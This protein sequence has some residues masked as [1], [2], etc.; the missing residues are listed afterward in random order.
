MIKK[1]FWAAAWLLCVNCG[2]LPPPVMPDTN[3]LLTPLMQPDSMCGFKGFG[4]VYFTVNGQRAKAK[5][6]VQWHGDSDCV[7]DVYSPLGGTL[8]SVRA[9]P[10]GAWTITQ[11]GSSLKKLP[12]DRVALIEG[13]EAYPFSYVQ[14][15][16]IIIGK[17]PN[18]SFCTQKPDSMIIEEKK[19]ALLWRADSAQGRPYAITALIHRKHSTI[20]DVLY[21][22]KGSTPW[23][24]TFSS[25]T[26]GNAKEIRFKD[27]HNNYFYVRYD[28]VVSQKKATGCRKGN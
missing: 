13:A 15:A 24:L 8:A 12:S 14:F 4:D 25:F 20:T 23:S 18:R 6:D 9:D 21:D 1:M 26:G 3:T 19:T 11:A 7:I 17:L 22:K 5:V 2:S 16:A 27:E 10:S 28:R